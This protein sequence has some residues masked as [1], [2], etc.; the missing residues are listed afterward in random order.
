MDK[1]FRSLDHTVRE[2]K[3]G[4]R[5]DT[6]EPA[7]GVGVASASTGARPSGNC[8]RQNE[9]TGEAGHLIA[10]HVHT[11]LSIPPTRL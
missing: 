2:R 5:V 9:A 4:G 10:D 1:D 7:A 8:P 11:L 3:V 6:E